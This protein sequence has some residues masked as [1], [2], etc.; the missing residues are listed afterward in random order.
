MN[1]K[2]AL[3]TKINNSTTKNN[4]YKQ[5][6]QTYVNILEFNCNRLRD[7][8]VNIPGKTKRNKRGLINGLGSII[9]SI[10]GNLDSSDEQKYERMFNNMEKNQ[11]ILQNQNLDTI[12]I[13]K[14]MIDKFNSQIDN[15]KHNEITLKSK[16]MQIETLLKES[17]N[18]QNVL[19]IKDIINQLILLTI[20]LI[21]I[22][23]EIE[24]SLTFCNLNKIHS[25]IITI[26]QL[27]KITNKINNI[28]FWD[29]STQVTSHCKLENEMIE[30]LLE[31]PVYGK[32]NRKLIQITPIPMYTNGKMYMLDI[33]KELV[34]RN[35]NKL[36]KMENCFKIQNN[37]YCKTNYIETSICLSNIINLQNNADCKYHQIHESFVIIK[38]K[39]SNIVI[40]ASNI[41]QNLNIKCKDYEKHKQIIGIY[42][43]KTDKNCVINEYNLENYAVNSKEIIFENYDFK[44]ENKQLSNKTFELKQIDKQNVIVNEVPKIQK[45]KVENHHSII[46]SVIIITILILIAIVAIVI[47]RNK[48]IKKNDI[49]KPKVELKRIQIEDK[50]PF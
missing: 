7:K 47:K 41:N 16:I 29:I 36:V 38:V 40:I 46:N 37:Y 33:S 17:T 49:T 34:I 10:T 18:W 23:S 2:N 31:I 6:L 3:L 26:D 45:I 44:I 32:N 1:H 39:D 43:F 20:N 12:K 25:S 50:A 30:Y 8:L 48:H 15:I 13:N 24:T 27:R 42:K 11:E 22:I 9:K 21:E 14:E 35:N 28:N 5:E 4:S 19:V